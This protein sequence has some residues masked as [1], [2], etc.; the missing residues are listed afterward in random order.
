MHCTRN[1]FLAFENEYTC[2]SCGYNVIKGK[3]EL[4]KF[5]R[6]KINFVNR[7]ECAQQNLF[8]ICIAV[9]KIYEVNDINE[10]SN[11]LSRIKNEN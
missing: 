9:Y 3:N 7:L 11:V 2:I 10:I 4:S 5:S 6:K 1:T 8:C